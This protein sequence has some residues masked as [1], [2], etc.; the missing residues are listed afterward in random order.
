LDARPGSGKKISRAAALAIA[1]AF[2]GAVTVFVW[3][4]ADNAELTMG[5]IAASALIG[6]AI[7]LVVAVILIV[8]AMSQ[9][10][11]SISRMRT[12][13]ALLLG[14]LGL[15][16]WLLLEPTILIGLVVG[17]SATVYFLIVLAWVFDPWHTRR[18]EQQER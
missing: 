13:S 11:A 16:A 10:R 8:L 2:A 1:I 15:W 14:G 6:A 5:E 7:G 17:L 12:P 9:F 3:L 4:V 18:S